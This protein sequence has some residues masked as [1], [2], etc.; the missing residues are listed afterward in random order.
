MQREG[1]KPMQRK[2]RLMTKKR[3]ALSDEDQLK[4]WKAAIALMDGRSGITKMMQ[5]AIRM[6]EQRDSLI[7]LL[8]IECERLENAIYEQREG[9]R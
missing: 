6:I 9:A 1:K 3:K 8:N 4:I 7:E 5:R 2:A